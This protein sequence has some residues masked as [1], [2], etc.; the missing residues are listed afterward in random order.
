[1]RKSDDAYKHASYGDRTIN[2][3]A[4]D[5]IT[6][7]PMSDFTDVETP[8]PDEYR[9]TLKQFETASEGVVRTV[10]AVSGQMPVHDDEAVD[11]RL[12]TALDPLYEAI[13]P[14]ALDALFDTNTRRTTRSDLSVSFPY[15]E[16]TVTVGDGDTITVE[17]LV[18]E[19]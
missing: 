4:P 9:Y 13:D 12:L 5:L 14:D 8:A 17:P 2:H 3:H 18:A 6:D 19:E 15:N 7:Y 10:A 1:M 16:H 11:G